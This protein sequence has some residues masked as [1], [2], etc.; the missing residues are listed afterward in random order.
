MAQRDENERWFEFDAEIACF[1]RMKDNMSGGWGRGY[2][3]IDEKLAA[4]IAEQARR[5]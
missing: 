2:K 5:L 3:I 1:A 4:Q